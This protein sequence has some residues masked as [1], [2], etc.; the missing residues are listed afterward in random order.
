MHNKSYTADSATIV[1]GRNIGDEYCAASDGVLFADLDVVA[2]GSVVSE[3]AAEF[4][5]YWNSPSAYPAASS[6]ARVPQQAVDK[7]Y[8]AARRCEPP[9]V[10]GLCAG[11]GRSR[12]STDLLAGR[13]PLQWAETTLV[14]DDPARSARRARGLAVPAPAGDWPAP[15]VA[16]SGSPYFAAHPGRSRRPAHLRQ[17]GAGCAF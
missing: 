13:L 6:A 15:A 16:G 5:R 11:R 3:V 17:Q 1:G 12:F 10:P 2:T 9:G 4:D 14:S 8:A 7:V